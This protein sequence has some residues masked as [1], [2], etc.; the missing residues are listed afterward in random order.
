MKYWKH[1]SGTPEHIDFR[2]TTREIWEKEYKPLLHASKS[3]MTA[4]RDK[5]ALESA[6]KRGV[7]A[8]YGN[9]GFWEIMRESLG[10]ICMFE[11]LLLDPEWVLDFNKVYLE[12]FKKQYTMLFE[13][14]GLPDG[15]WLYDDLAYKNG[16]FCSPEVLNEL[17]FPFYKDLADFFHSH[18]LPVVFHCCGNAE[19]AIPMIVEAGYDALNPMERKAG[20]DPLKFAKMYKDKLAFIGG[21]NAVTLENGDKEK[22]LEETRELIE[23]MRE[24]DA[25][26]I[27]GSDH[28]L[29]PN[30]KYED[31]KLAVDYCKQHCFY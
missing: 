18:N 8:S 9:L 23:G 4:Q 1:K 31:F 12:F 19:G 27:F 28:S 21:L 26:Y 10:D 15:I 13:E 7:W 24:I 20:C 22:I 25:A 16:T 5:A 17:Y 14:A 3:R 30:V 11:T 2:M 29:S 6:R